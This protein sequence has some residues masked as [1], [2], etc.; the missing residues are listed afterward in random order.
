LLIFIKKIF[1]QKPVE[2]AKLRIDKPNGYFVLIENEAETGAPLRIFGYIANTIKKYEDGKFLN[3][4][5]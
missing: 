3:S 4:V 1:S 5:E 2:A